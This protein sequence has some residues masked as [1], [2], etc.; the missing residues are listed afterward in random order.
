MN[1]SIF[2]SACASAAAAF[3]AMASP[4]PYPVAPTDSSAIDN[5]FGIKLA[6]PFRPLEDDNAPATLEWVKAENAL[7][8]SYLDQIPGRDN[9]RG[10]LEALYNFPRRGLPA[11]END[12]NYYFYH[13]DGLQNQ[14]ILYRTKNPA[15]KGKAEV[16]IDPNKLSDDGTVALKAVAMSPSGKLTAYTISRNGSDWEEIQV[17]DTKSKRLLKDH[18]EWAKFTT[19]SWNGDDGFYYSAYPRPE[20]SEL[21][22]ANTGHTVYYHKIGTPQSE[23]KEVFADPK[24]PLHFHQGWKPEKSPVLFVTASGQ[25]NGQSIKMKRLDRDNAGWITIEPTQDYDHNIL[26]VTPEGKIYILTFEGAPNGKV[27][28]ATIDNPGKEFW[29]PLV[30]EDPKGVIQGA[31]LAGENGIVVSY[32][33]DASSRLALID[34]TTGS[35]LK[36]IPLPGLGSAGV[37]SSRKNNTDLYY[38]YSSF[39]TPAEIHRYNMTTGEDELIFRPDGKGVNPED[40]LTEQVFFTSVDGTKVPM[41]VTH[42]KDVNLKSGDNP[43]WLYGYGG[44]NIPITPGYSPAKMLWVDNGGVLVNVNLRG[45]SEYG[46]PWHLAG[47]KLQK[48]NVFD[49]F[50]SAA[51]HLI[52][53]KVTNPERIVIEGGSNGGL[54]VGAVTNQRP[55]LFKVAFPRVGVM[56]MMRYHL[57]TIGWNWAHDYGRS[58]DS[59]AMAKYLLGYSPMHNIR[60]DATPYPAVMVTTADHD[61]R[62]VP[63]H[64]FKYA[65]TLQEAN[66]GDA[67]KLIRIDTNAGHGGGKPVS[68][69]IDEWVDIFSFAYKNLGIPVPQK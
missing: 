43:V 14:S 39:S 56:D 69:T 24:H 28:T 21:S 10:R 17:M 64:S 13:N 52:D 61:D 67:P 46:E 7:T 30:A 2:L 15:K 41:F 38:S 44:F 23:D 32:L 45:G 34:A 68:K 35:L 40:Y 5:Y 12:G 51:Q 26:D 62:V 33:R 16:F 11:K 25:G 50:I 37:S 8:R 54:L 20:G 4:L 19:P 27:M 55:D 31:S 3:S 48:Q 58:D 63:A 42:R 1:K 65:A 66:T 57:F 9:L 53:T 6:D 29:Q 60:N 22:A 47:T 18:I 59:P 49:D 36:D